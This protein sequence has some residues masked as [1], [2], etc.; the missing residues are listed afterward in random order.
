M[1]FQWYG[2]SATGGFA[3]V[4]KRSCSDGTEV[5]SSNCGCSGGGTGLVRSGPRMELSSANMAPFSKT[6]LSPGL[7]DRAQICKPG[8]LELAYHT[9]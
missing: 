3:Q 1:A 8:V 6:L 7:R 9:T 2:A 5:R 4:A